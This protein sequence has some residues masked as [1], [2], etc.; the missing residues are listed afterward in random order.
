MFNIL[1]PFVSVYYLP[2]VLQNEKGC[3]SEEIIEVVSNEES[4][5]SH[6]DLLL[7]RRRRTSSPLRRGLR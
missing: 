3:L 6:P 5:P 4:H 2:K 7:S 1:S